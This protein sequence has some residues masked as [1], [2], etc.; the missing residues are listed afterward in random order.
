MT[1]TRELYDR[2]ACPAG[3]VGYEDCVLLDQ[4]IKTAK[5]SVRE[6]MMPV[7]FPVHR[8]LYNNPSI[9][10]IPPG[11]HACPH[12]AADLSG[13]WGG[14]DGPDFDR[15]RT[16]APPWAQGFEVPVP[17]VGHARAPQRSQERVH[18]KLRTAPLGNVSEGGN[19]L[20]NSGQKESG[21]PSCTT[22]VPLQ[23]RQEQAPKALHPEGEQE[24]EKNLG[25]PLPG[26]R[27]GSLGSTV[28]PIPG[29]RREPVLAGSRKI[30]SPADAPREIKAKNLPLSS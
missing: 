10:Q 4:L 1:K 21:T 14:L 25:P 15:A 3:R 27:S 9:F 11:Y 29:T 18:R 2:P 30:P 13:D 6:S 5:S 17:P 12:P 22:R 20:W 8:V 26:G 19:P 7:S 24:K 23:M 16:L 28:V